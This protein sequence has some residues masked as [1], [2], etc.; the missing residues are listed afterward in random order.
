MQGKATEAQV[1]VPVACPTHCGLSTRS[2]PDRR[3]PH[4]PAGPVRRPGGRLRVCGDNDRLRG[5]DQLGGSVGRYRRH[6]GGRAGRLTAML[7]HYALCCCVRSVLHCVKR[8]CASAAP[9]SAD[10]KRNFF[11]CSWLSFWPPC[12]CAAAAPTLRTYRTP[13]MCRP[14]ARSSWPL[15]GCKCPSTVTTTQ[16]QHCDRK[17]SVP[18]T[19]CV[20]ILRCRQ[21]VRIWQRRE[22]RFPRGARRGHH[23]GQRSGRCHDGHAKQAHARH[24]SHSSL[25]VDPN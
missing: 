19:C 8:L 13:S 10:E 12:P 2:A 25:F 15:A 6:W 20:V 17:Q 1:R 21:P 4:R 9:A 16:F 11:L 22:C 3:L 23:A 5:E 7:C 24:F 14:R 18:N